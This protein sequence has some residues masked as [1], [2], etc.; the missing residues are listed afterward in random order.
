MWGVHVGRANDIWRQVLMTVTPSR[1]AEDR[2]H[3]MPGNPSADGKGIGDAESEWRR[4]TLHTLKD[5]SGREG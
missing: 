3:G 5:G 1:A 2:L 4:D